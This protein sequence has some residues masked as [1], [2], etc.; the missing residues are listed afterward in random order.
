MCVEQQ[1]IDRGVDA[2][3]GKVAEPRHCE[4]RIGLPGEIGQRNQKVR[5]ELQPAQ[6]RHQTIF[7]YV[8]GARA[9]GDLG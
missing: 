7:G 5:L 8:F 6:R 3:I 9:G 2:G 1:E 4:R